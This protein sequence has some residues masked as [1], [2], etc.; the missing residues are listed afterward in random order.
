MSTFSS[1]LLKIHRKVKL[2]EGWAST[3]IIKIIIIIMIIIL[4][5][6]IMTSMLMIKLLKVMFFDQCDAEPYDADKIKQN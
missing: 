6:I 4:I 5:M 2:F 3:L 1:P